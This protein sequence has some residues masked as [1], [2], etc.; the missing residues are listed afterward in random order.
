MDKLKQIC[1]ETNTS[2]E[3][4]K[5]RLDYYQKSLGWSEDDAIAYIIQLFENGTIDTI[6]FI[7]KDYKEI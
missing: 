6:K 7:G 2:F 1:K 4:I 5:M 3:D